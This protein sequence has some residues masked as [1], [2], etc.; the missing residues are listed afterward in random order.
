LAIFDQYLV[1]PQKRRKRCQL[2]STDDRRR[3]LSHWASTFVYN[4]MRGDSCSVLRVWIC[5][6]EEWSYIY[7]TARQKCRIAVLRIRTDAAY[8]YRCSV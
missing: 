6:T 5:R 8:C 3:S 1:I 7:A 4:T 2:S